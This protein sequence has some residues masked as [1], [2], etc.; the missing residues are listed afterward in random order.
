MAERITDDSDDVTQWL[1]EM[2]QGDSQ[3]AERLWKRYFGR[4]VRLARRHLARVPR[5]AADEEDVA[6]SAFNSFCGGVARGRFPQLNDRHDL[7]K[8]LMTL[9][10]RKAIGEVRR[11][12]AVKRGGGRVR[13]GS[14]WRRSA[15]DG[16]EGIE[17]VPSREPSPDLAAEV[18]ETCAALLTQLGDPSLQQIA[19]VKLQG[20]SNEEIAAQLG[21]AVRSVERKLARIREKWTQWQDAGVSS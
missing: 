11:Q 10:A 14:V 15:Q 5:R 3:A 18:A 20:F 9:T 13:G 7:W 17:Q 4:L 2:A 8:L 21:C 16:P 6:L 12:R 1:S 19:T